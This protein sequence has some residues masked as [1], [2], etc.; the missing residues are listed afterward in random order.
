MREVPRP[1]CLLDANILVADRR[2]RG[3][4]AV[5]FLRT[6]ARGELDAAVPWVAL[7]EAVNDFREAAVAAA[8]ALKETRRQLLGLG[9]DWSHTI[10]PTAET[11]AYRSWLLDVLRAHDIAVLPVPDA[12][13]DDL[14]RW[15]IAGRKPFKPGGNGYRDALIWHSVLTTS[16]ER[17][18]FFVTANASDFA[19][20]KN[21]KDELAP[22]LVEDVAAVGGGDG[23]VQLMPSLSDLL[24]AIA[25][26]AADIVEALNRAFETSRPVRL[27]LINPLKEAIVESQTYDLEVADV[28]GPVVE[29]LQEMVHEPITL[30]VERATGTDPDVY[31]LKLY[32]EADVDVH[33]TW[34]K[35]GSEFPPTALDIT[36]RRARQ[37]PSGTRSTRPTTEPTTAFTM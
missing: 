15:D 18:V 5:A 36:S 27:A 4:P 20:G 30:Q 16:R 11:E 21:S 25:G 12:P 14:V 3:A 22:A 37:R 34:M 35:P 8:R 7:E 32:V 26:E 10:D 2:L 31:L 33:V 6:L 1:L 13:H 28:P 24:E 9:I 19:A 17:P 23:S 29:I